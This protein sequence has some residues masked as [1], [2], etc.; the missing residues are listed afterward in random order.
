MT[1]NIEN[2]SAALTDQELVTIYKLEQ[3]C[4]HAVITI[5][6]DRHR[7]SIT[8]HAGSRVRDHD[9]AKDIAQEVCIR[10]ARHLHRFDERAQFTS[11]IYRITEN[12]CKTRQGKNARYQALHTALQLESS[13]S[14]APHSMAQTCLSAAAIQAEKI[15][16]VRIALQHLSQRDRNILELRF[17][18]EL[19]LD[20]LANTLGV[21]ISA[22]KMRFYR[23]LE[24]F[25][26]AYKHPAQQPAPVPQ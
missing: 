25:G 10:I 6:I 17:Y 18:Q 8:Q 23:A 24:R 15:Q 2:I 21:S 7:A 19:N 22:C 13:T 5:L 20:A 9:T 11:W 26:H 16:A 3:H 14:A 4:R 12:Q 1:T